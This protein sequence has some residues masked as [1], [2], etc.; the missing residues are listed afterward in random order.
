[1]NRDCSASLGN[2][3]QCPTVFM[4]WKAFFM[5]TLNHSCFS[6]CPLSLVPQLF[7]RSPSARTPEPFL[8]SCTSAWFNCKSFFLPRYSTWHLSLLDFLRSQLSTPA[9][10]LDPS[11]WQ[12]CPSAYQLLPTIWCHL[13]P[14]WAHTSLPPPARRFNPFVSSSCYREGDHFLHS[15]NGTVGIVLPIFV[16]GLVFASEMSS[17]GLS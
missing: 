3:F 8:Q 7:S 11:D 4:V 9:A 10:C 1:M 15:R 17:P 2:L 6:L 12:P 13:Q 14:C 5:S 16:W